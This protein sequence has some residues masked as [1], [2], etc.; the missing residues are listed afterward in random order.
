MNGFTAED[1]AATIRELFKLSVIM[2][3]RRFDTGALRIDQPKLCFHL[4]PE[5][6]MPLSTFVYENKESHRSVYL[7][8]GFTV[9][10]DY[11]AAV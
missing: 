6:Q 5:N 10:V 3:K 1:C 4:N 7:G 9:I 11:N 2:R 8:C